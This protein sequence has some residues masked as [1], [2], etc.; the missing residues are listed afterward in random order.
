M[1]GMKVRLR[2]EFMPGACALVDADVAL[3]VRAG[4]DEVLVIGK[5]LEAMELQWRKEHPEAWAA[6]QALKQAQ[7]PEEDFAGQPAQTQ[8]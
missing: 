6:E 3:Q 4:Q 2:V 7:E 5:V 8:T 1:S